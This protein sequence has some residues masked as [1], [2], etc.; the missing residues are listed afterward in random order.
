MRKLFPFFY[1]KQK[2]FQLFR[3]DAKRVSTFCLIKNYKIFHFFRQ[4]AKKVSLFLQ[5][6]KCFNFFVKMLKKFLFFC[7]SKKCFTFFDKKLK[8][9]HVL[10]N[11]RSNF[12]TRCKNWSTIFTFA[13]TLSVFSNMCAEKSTGFLIQTLQTCAKVVSLIWL[14]S[15][16]FLK[17]CF[18]LSYSSVLIVKEKLKKKCETIG[19]LT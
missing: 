4:D 11:M 5:K 3:Q 6:Q 17:Q 9:F 15:N 18:A 19:T 2:R 10:D 13:Q 16:R 7:K 1:K 8:A 14:C 12:L